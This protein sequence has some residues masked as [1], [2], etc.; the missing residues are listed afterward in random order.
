MIKTHLVIPDSH[1]H[2]NDDL[3]RFLALG[4]LIVAS[5][6]DKINILGDFGEFG[7]LC[8]YTKPGG[9][10]R[11]GMRI[12]DDIQACI[13]AYTLLMCPVD[14]YNRKQ[15]KLR[16]KQ[17]KPEVNF[18]E[19]NHEYRLRRLAETDAVFE[20]LVDLKGHLKTVYPLNW[21]EYGDYAK[22]DGV[23]YTHVPFKFGS[24]I[25]SVVNTCGTALD[26][27]DRSVVFGHTHRLEIKQK[28][29]EGSNKLITALNAGCFFSHLPKYVEKSNPNWWRGVVLLR[30]DEASGAF[31]IETI[32]LERLLAEYGV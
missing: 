22:V 9:L 17:Y 6:P 24:P 20:G 7:S 11:E 26:L 31:D 14:C 2:I 3:S 28:I 13:D 18:L 4:R 19:A 1:T 30:V 32:S 23:L 10:E 29:R 25:Q 8:Y 5:K 12:K 16:S 15:V 27:V 21:Y